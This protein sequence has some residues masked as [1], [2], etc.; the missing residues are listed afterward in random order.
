MTPQPVLVDA[1]I[2]PPAAAMDGR[3]GSTVISKRIREGNV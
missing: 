2:V 3:D 1:V